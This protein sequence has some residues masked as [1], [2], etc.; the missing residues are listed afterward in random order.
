M[1][2]GTTVQRMRPVRLRRQPRVSVVV[3]VYNYA[4]Y[5]PACIASA[6]AQEGVTVDILV[7]DDCSTDLS[8][9]VASAIALDDQRVRAIRNER[10]RGHIDTFNI[11]L[12]RVNGEYV[13]KLDA[14]DMLTPGA[15]ARAASL[16][17][18]NPHVG[19]AYGHPA[20]FT[21]QP[22]PLARQHVRGWTIWPGDEWLARRCRSG[23][24]CIHNPEVVMRASVLHEV[25]GH[26]HEV[27]QASDFELWLR[28]AAVSNVG[29]INGPD[30]AYYRVHSDSM[31]RTV[32][33]GTMTDLRGRRDAFASAFAGPAG[34]LA[35]AI[36]LESEARRTLAAEALDIACRAYERG[37]VASTPVDE[38]LTFAHD[39]WPN[40]SALKQSRA[41]ARRQ[42][43]GFPSKTGAPQF[44][45]RTI[46]RRAGEEVARWR[47]HRTG[48]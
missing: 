22:V 7:V 10:N 34:N 2:T 14:D 13:V 30:Q 20:Q 21:Q 31:Q 8:Y 27:P 42:R 5:L 46:L 37:R 38:L 12:F 26:R 1:S 43:A 41:L 23:H 18:A 48:V 17:D 19:F 40:A 6:R 3:P 32:H 11:G 33:A 28:M 35:N 29:R 39:V 45:A 44:V 47:W 9:Y 25:G 36:E 24:N 16:L 15:L 4:R